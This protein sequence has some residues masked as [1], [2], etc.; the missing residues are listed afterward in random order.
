MFSKAETKQRAFNPNIPLGTIAE[1]ELRELFSCSQGQLDA[2]LVAAGLLKDAI[3]VEASPVVTVRYYG[4][5]AVQRQLWPL[6]AHVADFDH[7]PGGYTS[8]SEAAKQLGQTEV[9]AN[10]YA[11]QIVWCTYRPDRPPWPYVSPEA[12]EELRLLATD[13]V[14]PSFILEKDVRDLLG[15]RPDELKKLVGDLGLTPRIFPHGP[16]NKPL[17]FWHRNDVQKLYEER[18][19]KK[20]EKCREAPPGYSSV[21]AFAQQC[22]IEPERLYHLLRKHPL[23]FVRVHMPLGGAERVVKYYK[24]T[25]LE[26][27]ADIAPNP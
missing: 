8:V 26:A 22:G 11:T 12:Y 9:W 18:K 17:R 21:S 25:D 16:R 13:G 20:G 1:H 27:I 24:L 14:D 10:R 19:R 15:I 7:V 5:E 2:A 6:L 4:L 23:P 3:E